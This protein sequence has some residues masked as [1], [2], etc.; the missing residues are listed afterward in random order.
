M[1]FAGER[2]CGQRRGGKLVHESPGAVRRAG[3]GRRGSPRR[4]SPPLP[5][6]PLLLFRA[7]ESEPR[8]LPRG[9]RDRPASRPSTPTPAR[10]SAPGHRVPLENFAR[11][12][13]LASQE[14]EKVRGATLRWARGAGRAGGRL[15]AGAL[16]GAR[17]AGA[18]A[19]CRPPGE[20]APAC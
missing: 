11:K 20:A 4:G 5:P 15:A 12:R 16:R 1:V 2:L 8:R 10:L 9:R 7:A 19:V 13:K 3:W 6:L 18:R 14:D 17:H